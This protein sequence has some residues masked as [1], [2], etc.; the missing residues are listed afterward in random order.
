MENEHIHRITTDSYSVTASYR[1]KISGDYLVG[2]SFCSELDQPNHKLGRMIARGRLA[3]N[4]LCI[5]SISENLSE[6]AFIEG[7]IIR[8][9]DEYYTSYMLANPFKRTQLEKLHR[10]PRWVG[11]FLQEYYHKVNEFYWQNVVCKEGE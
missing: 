7:A 10:V 4:P 3:K 5:Y 6:H 11:K 1:K 8:Y 9:L 2:L